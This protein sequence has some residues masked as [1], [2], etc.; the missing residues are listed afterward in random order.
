MIVGD[1]DHERGVRDLVLMA[2][3]I[4]GADTPVDV[5]EDDPA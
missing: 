2:R 5:D 4:F 3:R 1:D